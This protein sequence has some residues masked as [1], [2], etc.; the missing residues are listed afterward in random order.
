M[1]FHGSNGSLVMGVQSYLQRTGVGAGFHS[2]K[3]GA[4]PGSTC[5]ISRYWLSVDS[6]VDSARL[7]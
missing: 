4:T 7:E 2:N 5:L 1:I 3:A 6:E